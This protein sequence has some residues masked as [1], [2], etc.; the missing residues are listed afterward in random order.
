[1]SHF[2]FKDPYVSLGGVNLS[3][4]VKQVTLDYKAET[5]DDTCAGDDTRKRLAGGLKDWS[6]QVEFAQDYAASQVDATLFALVGTSVAVEVRPTSAAV[7]STNPKFTGNALL[8]SYQPMGG[9]I[10]DAAMAPV[11]LQGNGDLTRA[12]S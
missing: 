4:H 5:P 10:G 1:M 12:T 6:L 9:S 8:E 7:G 3:A 11:T 2:V